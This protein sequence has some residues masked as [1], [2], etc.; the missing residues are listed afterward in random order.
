LEQ[1]GWYLGKYLTKDMLLSPNA[2][3]RRYSSSRDVK[4][5]NPEKS[6]WKPVKF[7]METLHRAAKGH[8]VHETLDE[9]SH[10]KSFVVEEEIIDVRPTEYVEEQK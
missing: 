9:N 10:V 5:G 1:I 2:P 3:R 8:I 7:T 6:G 4:L